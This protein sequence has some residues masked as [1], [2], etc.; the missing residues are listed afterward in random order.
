MGDEQEKCLRSLVVLKGL[1]EF[2]KRRINLNVNPFLLFL[3]SCSEIGLGYAPEG[4]NV[5]RSIGIVDAFDLEEGSVGVGVALA[6]L[7]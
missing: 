1:G 5:L 4:G 7:V 2:L 6:T 3:V